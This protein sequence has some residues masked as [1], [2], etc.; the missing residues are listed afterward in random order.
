MNNKMQRYLVNGSI[1]IAVLL[2]V[3]LGFKFEF[4]TALDILVSSDPIWV[5]ALAAV[6]IGS[7]VLRGIKWNW[8]LRAV[9]IQ[10]PYP[11]A[12]RLVFESLFLGAMTPGM[13]GADVYRILALRDKNDNALV[14]SS[15]LLERYV[16]LVSVVALLLLGLP[17]TSDIWFVDDRLSL[18]VTTMSV[19]L[20][21][22]IP[23]SIFLF[24]NN[25]SDYSFL[26]YRPLKG[27]AGLLLKM[28]AALSD[29]AKRP[30]ALACFVAGGIFEVVLYV[31]LGYVA[32][33]AIG[34][35]VS[36]GYLLATMPVVFLIIRVPI[37]F[38]GIGVM[39]GAFIFA[40]A[41]V[42]VSP[43]QSLAL[44]LLIRIADWVFTILPGGALLVVSGVWQTR[45][46]LREQASS[47]G[48][49]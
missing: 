20:F 19:L 28:R 43:E 34:A 48:S 5:A 29:F 36:F 11:R 44:S 26:K 1:V 39:E 21:A 23:G 6:Y 35:P 46:E 7:R 32:L 14:V 31:L 16:G 10:V 8:L 38:Q 25:K 2:V 40:L 4:K 18:F 49:D 17:Q 24:M 22:M 12:V 33:K 37:S 13:L 27:V 15:L 41:P 47:L 9:A 45:Q 30:L 42:G 3:Y